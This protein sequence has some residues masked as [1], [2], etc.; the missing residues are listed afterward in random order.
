MFVVEI[1]A[2]RNL[3]LEAV[4]AGGVLV[5]AFSAEGS[6]DRKGSHLIREG[7]HEGKND[8]IHSCH[9]SLS[10]CSLCWRGWQTCKQTLFNFWF[11][12]SLSCSGRVPGL[13]GRW[14]LWAGGGPRVGRGQAWGP[15][16]WRSLGPLSVCRGFAGITTVCP[17]RHKERC[18]SM[19]AAMCWNK[20]CYD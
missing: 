15:S 4:W 17:I 3:S 9:A 5:G 19:I 6:D 7:K 16:S 18:L 12:S 11:G 10:S 14:L 8:R 13:L 20:P 1:S 2:C